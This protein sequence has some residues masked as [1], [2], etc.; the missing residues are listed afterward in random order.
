MS[1]RT[2]SDQAFHI[3]I[4]ITLLLL[5]LCPSIH[6]QHTRTHDTRKLPSLSNLLTDCSSSSSLASPMLCVL[7]VARPLLVL[8]SLY[9]ALF[10]AQ[11]FVIEAIYLNVTFNGVMSCT[12][13]LSRK[14]SKQR[15]FSLFH[16]DTHSLPPSRPQG[17]ACSSSYT[18]TYT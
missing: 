7:H 1:A 11:G 3:H 2:N 14:A 4:T 13:P 6:T 15:K 10:C 18:H 16:P 5:L 12:S 8:S 9:P 17:Q